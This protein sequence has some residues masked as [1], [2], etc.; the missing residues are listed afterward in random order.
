M[1]QAMYIIILCLETE[2]LTTNEGSI[3]EGI[4]K[5]ID[6]SVYLFA[7]IGNRENANKV[8]Y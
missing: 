1:H 7:N 5:I 3:L 4:N 8:S 6:S 2:Q